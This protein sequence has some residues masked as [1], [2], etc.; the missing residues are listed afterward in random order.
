MNIQADIHP[1]FMDHFKSQLLF[2][3]VS[4]SDIRVIFDGGGFQDRH[5]LM[6]TLLKRS[7][8]D[9]P[10][11]KTLRFWIFTGDNRPA[12]SI[13]GL[14]L[15][16]ISG[17][18]HKS[19]L[20]LP[21]PYIVKWSQVG[22]EDYELYCKEIT[23]NS[24]GRPENLSVVWRGSSSMHPVRSMIINQFN[25][26]NNPLFDIRDT[27]PD[28]DNNSFIQ[29]KD[30]T[31][32]AILCDMPGRGYSARLKY[33]LRAHRPVVVFEREE[34]DAVT[35][36]MEP[37]ID[38]VSCP[39]DVKIFNYTVEKIISQYDNFIS[40]TKRTVDL[41]SKITDSKNVSTLLVKKI[42][43]NVD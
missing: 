8:L 1:N 30:L 42:N 10:S 28:P 6:T 14:P 2:Y 17:P 40:R 38:F 43:S 27:P 37:G 34:W 23:K 29:M 16:S 25:R 5:Y 35:M 26:I 41:M 39:P 18:R 32:W 13:N 9:F 22:V 7:F 21:D 19:N 3:E 24:L 15:F 12:D 11:K 36:L 20:I 31:K 33:L 4:K